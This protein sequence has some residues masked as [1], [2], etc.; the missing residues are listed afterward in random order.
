MGEDIECNLVWINLAGH[1][2]T[3]D[4][5]IDLALQFCN[6]LRSRSGNRLIAGCEN[7]LAPEGCM[8]RV[9]CHQRDG[10]G[11]VGIGY[12]PL[13]QAN[14]SCVDFR[15]DKR[16]I[17]IHTERTG[18]VN[19]HTTCFYRNRAKFPRDAPTGAKQGNVDS[20]ERILGQLLYGDFLTTKVQLLPDGTG[21][22]QQGQLPR[23][24][25]T[26]LERLDHFKANGTRRT[27]HGNM[28]ILIHIKAVKYN[29]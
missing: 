15:D 2:L 25:M 8:K 21:G 23:R 19:D 24:E 6:S 1:G 7:P 13:V 10:R 12:D 29:D 28:R 27:N 14:V 5:L 11:A 17:R 3:V 22:S 4:D 9:E 20:V 26:L 18:I 16:H